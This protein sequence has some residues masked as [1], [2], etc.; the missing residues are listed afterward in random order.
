MKATFLNHLYICIFSLKD[1]CPLDKQEALITRVS[2]KS[3]RLL[4][5]MFLFVVC[6]VVLFLVRQ[7]Q[8]FSGLIPDLCLEVISGGSQGTIYCVIMELRWS[9]AKQV[10]YYCSKAKCHIHM[11][12]GE[13]EGYAEIYEGLLEKNL[14]ILLN[15]QI[16]F[17]RIYLKKNI[18]NYMYKRNS[19]SFQ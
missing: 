2:R 19:I 8:Q 14:R 16:T 1:E 13:N 6:F 7:S 5:V 17:H 18:L 3:N 10:S 9:L 11:N 4:S 12:F 15:F